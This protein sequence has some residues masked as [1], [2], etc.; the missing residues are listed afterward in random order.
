[1]VELV[2]QVGLELSLGHLELAKSLLVHFH[3]QEK[4]KRELD[5]LRA[6]PSLLNLEIYF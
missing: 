3:F 6:D 4:D 1:M 2:G 5:D